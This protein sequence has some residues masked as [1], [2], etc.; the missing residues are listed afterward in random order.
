VNAFV[1]GLH[2][3]CYA[4]FNRFDQLV[5]VLFGTRWLV[6]SNGDTYLTAYFGSMFIAAACK[7]PYACNS[8]EISFR[9]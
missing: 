3:I 1:I 6:T 8:F 9:N 5:T 4:T 7:R 2:C